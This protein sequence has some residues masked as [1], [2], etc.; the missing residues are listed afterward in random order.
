M[1]ISHKEY[2]KARN[3]HFLAFF[4]KIWSNKRVG[5]IFNLYPMK[6]TH[7]M[8][9]GILGAIML[10]SLTFATTLADDFMYVNAT[11]LNVRASNTFRSSIVATVDNGYKVTVLESLENGWKKVLLENGQEGYMNGRYLSERAPYFE[12]ATGASY[13]VNV[14]QAFVR[15]DGLVRKVAVLHKGDTVDIMDRKVF[16]GKWLRVKIT[17]S[18]SGRYNERVGYI[19]KKLVTVMEETKFAEEYVPPSMDNTSMDQSATTGTVDDSWIS[20]SGAD[21]KIPATTTN[22]GPNMG[23]MNP[24]TS[25]TTPPT[26]STSMSDD[27]LSSIFGSLLK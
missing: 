10:S 24:T 7:I 19:S 12:K 22:M 6:K 18:A 1:N 21:M 26:A 14:P 16:L 15:A 9:R 17:S 5:L 25:T 13:T 27:D 3:I 2:K 4:K 23:N 8:S 11:H 20:D